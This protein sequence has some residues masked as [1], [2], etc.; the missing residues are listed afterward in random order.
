MVEDKPPRHLPTVASAIWEEGEKVSV[1]HS[2]I[3]SAH[4]VAKHPY[5]TL[6]FFSVAVL[7][8][9]KNNATERVDVKG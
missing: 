9:F 7:S 8:F 5:I 4:K 3:T 2:F 1:A 6:F